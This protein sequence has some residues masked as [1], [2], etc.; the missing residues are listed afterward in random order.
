MRPTSNNDFVA[1]G[2]TLTAAGKFQPWYVVFGRSSDAPPA[3]PPKLRTITSLTA[4]CPGAIDA[5]NAAQV[6]GVLSPRRQT[7]PI[8]VEFKSPSG[9]T[10]TVTATTGGAS[11]YVAQANPS[12]IGP[13]QVKA[14]YAGNADDERSSATCGF[15]VRAPQPGKLPSTLTMTCP[16]STGQEFTAFTVS[17]DLTPQPHFT[18][19]NVTWTPLGGGAPVTHGSLAIYGHYGDTYQ[20]AEGSWQVQASWPGDATYR[21]TSSQICYFTAYR[22]R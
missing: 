10:T 6:T 16:K 14:T 7:V 5:G 15:T 13:W 17:G 19:I 21:D 20:P 12:E 3:P 22:L 11:S 18:T 2:N 4:T 1:T 9:N 8:A